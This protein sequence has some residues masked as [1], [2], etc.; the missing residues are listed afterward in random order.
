MTSRGTVAARWTWPLGLVLALIFGVLAASPATAAPAAPGNLAPKSTTVKAN[1][2]LKW[3]RVRGAATYNVEASESKT[4][5]S[6]L[7]SARTTNRYATPTAQLPAG[8]VWWRVQGVTSTGTAGRWATASFTRARPAGP[9]LVAPES[10]SLF[11]QPENP[12][13]L[14]WAPVAGA[15]SYEVEIDTSEKDWVETKTFETGTTSLVVPDPQQPGTY[16]WRVRAHLDDALTTRPSSTWSYRVGAL[17]VVADATP[18]TPSGSTVTDI[19]EIVFDWDPVPGAI[20][21]DIRVSTDDWFNQRSSIPGREGDALLATHNVRQ[22]ELLVAGAPATSSAR[23]RSGT[24]S[25]S[26]SSA[27]PGKGRS[28]SFIRLTGP[29]SATTST[30]SGRRWN[31][32]RSTA[33]TS[34]RIPLSPMTGCSRPARDYNDL[35]GWIRQPAQ[36]LRTKTVHAGTRL[37]E[38]LE[39]PAA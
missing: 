28:L 11:K 8:R 33:L 9:R 6:L 37:D 39:S 5:G 29:R 24:R 34:G 38:L 16:W 1:P 32:R 23:R 3:S 21:Y 20:S 26:E 18:D 25:T 14:R 35:H 12:P 17:P 19:Q 2:V 36:D 31:W 30:S 7:F 13:L 27:A 10:G 22:R 4:F 15:T